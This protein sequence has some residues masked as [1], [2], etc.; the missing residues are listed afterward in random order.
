MTRFLDFARPLAVRLDRTDLTQVIDRAIGDVEK[1]QPP[2]DV[3][4]YKNYSPEIPPFL[5]TVN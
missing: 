1:H 5:S 2:F 3:A 4:I